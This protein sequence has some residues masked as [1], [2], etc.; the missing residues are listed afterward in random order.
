MLPMTVTS[1]YEKCRVI[2][3]TPLRGYVMKEFK[4]A[5]KIDLFDGNGNQW[6]MKGVVNAENEKEQFNTVSDGYT[7][8]QHQE[9]VSMVE[10]AVADKNLN[11]ITRIEEM[12]E[13]ARIRMQLTFPDITLD[14]EE[15]GQQVA[16]RCTYDNSYDG[17]TGL[18]LEVGAKSP[19]GGGF[20]WVGGI[21]RAL[22]DNYYH[23]HTKGVNV[24]EFEKKLEKGITSFQTK[25]KDHFKGMF[26]TPM[27]CETATNF[28]DDA[29]NDKKFK[30][31]LKY[32]ESIK[33]KVRSSN[34]KN[35]WQFYCLICDVIGQEIN[36][37]DNR[38][39]QLNML[40]SRL[41]RL[42]KN[43]NLPATMTEM[44]QHHTSNQ[45]ADLATLEL[46]GVN[47][48]DPNNFK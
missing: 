4:T 1:P 25:I 15:N 27:T 44:V 12:N 6:K 9:L 11:A 14:V 28:L 43:G 17:T 30:G 41:H 24:A 39:R 34:I 26:K 16:L 18:R 19:Y 22:E 40:V 47:V 13:G 45:G 46:N 29:I 35:K 21:V 48:E 8:V 3:L 37:V 31:S 33:N 42:V 20:L 38:E 5:K 23:R 10:E 36:S 7:I 2:L 32:A